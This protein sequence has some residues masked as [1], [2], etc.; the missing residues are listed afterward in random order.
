MSWDIDDIS[1]QILWLDARTGATSAAWADQ[2]ATGATVAQATAAN[3]PTIVPDG[4]FETMPVVRFDGTGDFFSITG[5]SHAAS[6][7]TFFVVANPSLLMERPYQYYIDIQTGRLI[8]A[9][10]GKHDGAGGYYNGSAWMDYA[11]A[12]GPQI[13]T[14]RLDSTNGAS[15]YRNGELMVSGKSYTQLAIGG[16]VKLGSFNA[17]AGS[18]FQGDIAAL[19]IYDTALSDDDM[20]LIV[21]KLA[22]DWKLSEYLAA[23][24]PYTSARFP[25]PEWGSSFGP[26]YQSMID[27]LA[28]GYE[29]REAVYGTINR[30]FD[31]RFEVQ[32]L[33]DLQ[34]LL[35]FFMAHMGRAYTFRHRDWSDY[36]A[37]SEFL[38]G[39]GSTWQLTKQYTAGNLVYNRTITRPVPWSVTLYDDGVA[40]DDANYSID[41]TTGIVTYTPTGTLMA[42]FEFDCLCRF[43]TDDLSQALSE[44]N[45][46]STVTVPL[47]EVGQ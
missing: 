6:D 3:R 16:N 10:V 29:R 35:S 20:R 1:G 26:T 17:S 37:E 25:V 22:A 46:G 11:S 7:Y 15:I 4:W 23:D 36:T 27:S 30:A 39:S 40:V 5:L 13:V 9:H 43:D 28:S 32:S 24:H 8:F 44:Y 38:T 14:M 34:E 21:G 33:E 45:L 12:T 31:C 18:L 47:L 19:A 42:D 41:Y 2:S